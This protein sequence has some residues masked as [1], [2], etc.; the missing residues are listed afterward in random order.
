MSSRNT[1]S[2]RVPGANARVVALKSLRERD[3]VIASGRKFTAVAAKA[4]KRSE[5]SGEE[6]IFFFVPDP[7]K[8]FI[9]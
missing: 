4:R 7:K 8:K 3:T 5:G 6:P 9:F 2:A 1:P